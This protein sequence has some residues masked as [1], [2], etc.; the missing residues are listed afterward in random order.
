MAQEMTVITQ[1]NAVN[2]EAWQQLLE[3]SPVATWFQTE[4]AY[5]FFASLPEMMTPFVFAVENEGVLRGLV[6][7]YVT[8]DTH[9]LKQFFTR[10]AIIYGGPLLADDIT[11]E[12][13]TAL[14]HAVS[15]SLKKQAIYIESRN[16]CDYSRWRDVFVQC[17]WK[18]KPHYDIHVDCTD[19][20]AMIGRLSKSKKQQIR[21]AQTEGIEVMEATE[22]EDIQAFYV[23]LQQLYR[24][25]VHR[26]LFSLDFFTTFVRQN[27]G[28]LLLVKQQGRIIGGT[29]CAVLQPKGVMYE[30]Y[31]V[32][33]AIVTWATM[34]Y[35]YAKGIA[36]LD[37]MG[38]GEPGV[39]YGVRDFKMEFGGEL[40]EYG[41]YLY[42]ANSCLYKIGKF[43][44]ERPLFNK[45]R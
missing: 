13:L 45:R 30:W 3:A 25:K 17:G 35:A 33:P 31:A 9:P 4:D 43:V 15:V 28:V 38:A 26:P 2:S 5:R 11:D 37:L 24:R 41:R 44:V 12:Q 16:F 40:R 27:K 6:V 14:L 10:R 18:Y 21:K 1:Y 22:L 8:K 36:M 19:R 39:P 29:L 32:G 23:L 20:N 7:G 42:C 34:E